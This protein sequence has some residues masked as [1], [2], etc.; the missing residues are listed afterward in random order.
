M[1]VKVWPLVLAQI[2]GGPAGV[3]RVMVSSRR[4][5]SQMTITFVRCALSR[6]RGFFAAFYVRVA[7]SSLFPSHCGL[8]LARDAGFSTGRLPSLEPL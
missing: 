7:L 2:Q 8:N 4:R 5:C 1:S 6:L 3:L